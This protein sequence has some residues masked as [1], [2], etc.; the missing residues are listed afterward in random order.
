MSCALPALKLLRLRESRFVHVDEKYWVFVCR[1]VFDTAST[2]DWMRGSAFTRA[3]GPCAALLGV[4]A[5][6]LDWP[7]D[8]A[9]NG[10]SGEPGAGAGAG[11]IATRA[12]AV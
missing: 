11:R 4:A 7:G 1:L 3:A 12:T 5:L 6:P 9:A 2:S 8:E 10:T